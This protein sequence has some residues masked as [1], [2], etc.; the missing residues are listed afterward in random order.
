MFDVFVCVL[1][2]KPQAI[3]THCVVIRGALT[4]HDQ[5]KLKVTWFRYDLR[6]FDLKSLKIIKLPFISFFRAVGFCTQLCRGCRVCASNSLKPLP[7]KTV[8]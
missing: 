4:N 2:S 8:H 3:T 5:Q 1:I 6:G 7:A